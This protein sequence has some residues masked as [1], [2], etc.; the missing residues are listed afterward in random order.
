LAA[1]SGRGGSA[2]AA[3]ATP[4]S[5]AAD[6]IAG[7]SASSSSAGSRWSRARSRSAV[8]SSHRYEKTMMTL[9]K[10]LLSVCTSELQATSERGVA[11]MATGP[12]EPIYVGQEAPDSNTRRRSRDRFHS[13]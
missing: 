9:L 4:A 13:C 7:W 12:H 6:A 10:S 5:T 8:A 3:A 1:T 2:S 11:S